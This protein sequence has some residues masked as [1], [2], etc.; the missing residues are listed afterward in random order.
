MLGHRLSS[1]LE[2]ISDL[3]WYSTSISIYILLFSIPVC[4]IWIRIGFYTVIGLLY[5]FTYLFIHDLISFALLIQFYLN[6]DN[7]VRFISI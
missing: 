5:L 1:S 7:R 3:T 2:N 6:K 4:W